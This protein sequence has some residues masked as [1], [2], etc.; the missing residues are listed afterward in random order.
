MNQSHINLSKINKCSAKSGALG[1]A[2]SMA[3]HFSSAHGYENV[4]CNNIGPGYVRTELTSSVF[5]DEE[6]AKRLADATIIGR[7]SE[8]EDLV[9]P[10]VFL[11]SKAS[12]YVTGQT[13]MVDGGF[14][15]LGMR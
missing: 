15:A 10:A 11:A 7:N 3:E 6:R 4:T 9:G 1:L 2:R 8:P 5:A 12:G 13:L 14:G